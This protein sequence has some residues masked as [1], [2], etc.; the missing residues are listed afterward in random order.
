MSIPAVSR[1]GRQAERGGA[2]RRRR[3]YLRSGLRRCRAARLPSGTYH[4]AALSA[5]PRGRRPGTYHVAAELRDAASRRPAPPGRRPAAGCQ[6]QGYTISRAGVRAARR[7]ARTQR[8]GSARCRLRFRRP[9][10]HVHPAGPRSALRDLVV[11]SEVSLTQ[12]RL[13]PQSTRRTP[14]RP[15]AP[16]PGLLPPA[17]CADNDGRDGIRVPGRMEGRIGQSHPGRTGVAGHR[18]RGV[19]GRPRPAPRA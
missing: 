7:S 11:A 15:P 13:V 18:G 3:G 14:R 9:V 10:D 1:A 2:L 8:P 17:G 19:R 4:V 16:T 6:T 5:G 12:L